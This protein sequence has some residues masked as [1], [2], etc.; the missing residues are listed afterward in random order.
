[1]LDSRPITRSDAMACRYALFLPLS[2]RIIAASQSR[3]TIVT[4]CGEVLA[5]EWDV[6]PAVVEHLRILDRLTGRTH[7]LADMVT[8]S[9]MLDETPADIV[10]EKVSA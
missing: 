10:T 3:E 4:A 5:G 6:E 9:N 8:P 1:M 2:G 7:T